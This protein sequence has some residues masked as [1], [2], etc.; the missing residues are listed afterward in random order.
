MKEFAPNL[1][2]VAAA[3]AFLDAV[4]ILISALCLEQVD[5][6]IFLGLLLGTIYA[7]LNHLALAY[8]VKCLTDKSTARARIFYIFSYLLRFSAAAICLVVGFVFLNPFAV[9][10]PMLSPKVGYYFMG[11]S[12]K[13]IQ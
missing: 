11:F 2:V 7:V 1:R 6:K 10:V 5:S 8:T 13:D 9:S 12:G 3:A 4:F